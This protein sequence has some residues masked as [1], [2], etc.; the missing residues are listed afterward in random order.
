MKKPLLIFVFAVFAI[1]AFSTAANAAVYISYVAS[2]GNDANPCTVVSAPCKTLARAYNVTSANG[3]IRVLTALQSNLNIAKNITIS[4]DGAPIV[5][6]F[7]ISGAS[8]KAILQGLQLNGV[9]ILANGIRI[10]SAAAVHIE[11]CTIERYAS[12]GIKLIASTATKLFISNTVSRANVSDGLYVDATNAQ[13]VIENSRFEGNG[14]TG[15]YLKVAN[16]KASVTGSVASG[17]GY[18][19]IILVNEGTITE[20]IA[21]NNSQNGFVTRT[22]ATMD[23]AKADGNGAAG[24]QI[25][26]TSSTAIMN[27]VFLGISPS[28]PGVNNQGIAYSYHHNIFV[29]RSGNPIIE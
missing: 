23:S 13:A 10:D 27:C 8:T 14:S 20:T 21:D 11:D 12:D 6:T 7:V 28:S 18:N 26:A 4:G 17:N 29:Y 19:G 2:N 24:L 25:D 22:Y 15:V 16:S 1:S 3:T 5:G 9:G